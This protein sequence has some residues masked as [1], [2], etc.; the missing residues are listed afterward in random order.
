MINV[1]NYTKGSLFGFLF[2]A[3]VLSMLSACGSDDMSPQLLAGQQVS[4]V[5]VNK[6]VAAAGSSSKALAAVAAL[7]TPASGTW[8]ETAYA[9]WIGA[10]AGY[11]AYVRTL[12]AFDWRDNAPIQGWLV[13]WEEADAQLVREVD[14][15][16]NTWRVDIPG[17]PRGEYEIQIRAAD[18]VAVVHT[19]AGLQTRSFPRYGAAFVPS[20]QDVFGFPGTHNFALNGAIGGYLPDGRED[21]TAIITYVTHE[22]M[23]TALPANIFSTGRGATANART[24]LIVR[25]LGTV[26]SFETVSTTKAG[27]GAV[28]PPGVNDSGRWIN[29]GTGNG[30]VTIEGI[31]PDANIFGWGMTIGGAHN[32]EFRNLRFDQWYDDAIFIDGAS[33]TVRSS[34]IWV[35]NNTF[36]YGQNKH[37]AL[38]QDPDQAKGDG[39]IDIHNH[40]RNYTINY[41]IFAGSSKS[42]LIGGGATAI[43][44]H[45]G[46][47]DHNWFHGSEERTPRV[48]NGRIH[49]FNNLYQDI[50]GHPYHNQLLAR[51]TGYG[52]GAGHNANIWAE[53]NIFDHVNF[54]FLRS[55]QGHARGSQVIN[56]EPGPGESAT[57]NAGFN[58]FFGDAPGFIIAREAVVGGDFPASVA[59]FRRT[60]DYVTGLTDPALDA[61]RQ[62]ALALE[63]NV[64]DAASLV[65]FNPLEDVGVVVAAGSTTTNPAM[66]TNPAAQLDW[67]FRPIRT[68]VWPTGTPAQATALRTEIETFSGAQAWLVPDAVPAAPLVSSVVINN[69]VRSAINAQFTP[70][71]GKIVIYENTF[72]IEWVNSDVLTTSYEIEWDG[73]SGTWAPIASVPASA[74]PTSFVTQKLNPLA[75]PATLTLLATATSREAMYVFRMRA[76]N[77]F[78]ASDWSHN[79]VLNGH[80]VTFDAAGGSAIAPVA[81][82]TGSAVAVP[83]AP[84]RANFLF[85]GWS[86]GVECEAP[87]DFATPVTADITLFACWDPAPAE[88]TSFVASPSSVTVGTPVTLTW[89]S[90][91]TTTICVGSGAWSGNMPPSGSQV[92]T[93]RAD[94]EMTFGLTCSAAGGDDTASVTVTAEKRK[95]GGGSM[96]WLPLAGLAVLLAS[97]RRRVLRSAEA[98]H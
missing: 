19:F 37:L 48:R 60:T 14:P 31:G 68:G 22:N 82:P 4:S 39:A 30:N 34:N 50:Q 1:K 69:E 59:G 64:L 17:L 11:R 40:A 24:P 75:T 57:A 15:A 83:T 46:T 21:P 80:T 16:R 10:D 55:R 49:V 70:A 93:P 45:Y 88:I 38:G 71:P 5:A 20:N 97:R 72:T 63:P 35:H 52:I 79:Y 81:V 61:L 56:Y 74:R 25:F 18:G 3:F 33:T 78:G 36:A 62:A 89:V 23:A 76:V 13:D 73:G 9:T 98:A 28:V 92:V 32:V 44:A 8:F 58:H 53:G 29:I 54:P 67:S 84:T 65:N 96:G 42:M 90:S 91:P 7:P 2:M 77:S 41:N 6:N 66:T 51:N 95:G 27:A 86:A 87:Y 85:G 47:V 26:G 43:S 94:G 12:G